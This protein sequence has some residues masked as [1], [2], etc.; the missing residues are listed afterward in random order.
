MWLRGARRSARCSAHTDDGTSGT[1]RR[2]E[3]S[4][5]RGERER[6]APVT[7]P[8]PPAEHTSPEERRGR[9]WVAGVAELARGAARDGMGR[10]HHGGGRGIL[11][12][13]RVSHRRG[14]SR[15]GAVSSH[16]RNWSIPT[17]Q[18]ADV[19]HR[20]RASV[21]HLMKGHPVAFAQSRNGDSPL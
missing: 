4:G 10:A 5:R 15:T 12:L 11:R 20:R 18:R 19:K 7:S 8:P 17:L 2:G 21:G 3:S 6:E 13:V 14:R 9:G 16:Q 1:R